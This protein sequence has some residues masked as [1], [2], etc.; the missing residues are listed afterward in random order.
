M[1]EGWLGDDP[2][3]ACHSDRWAPCVLL[4]GVCKAFWRW[5]FFNLGPVGCCFFL[6]RGLGVGEEDRLRFGGAES[7]EDFVVISLSFR[8]LS[9]ICTVSVSFWIVSVSVYVYCI[10]FYLLI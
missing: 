3:P 6:S 4:I 9:V 2:R 5:S 7:S 1:V 10:L 8:V